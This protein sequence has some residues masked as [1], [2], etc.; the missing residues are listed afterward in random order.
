M[1]VCILSIKC[2]NYIQLY[3]VQSKSRF[4]QRSHKGFKAET[5]DPDGLCSNPS[6]TPYQLCVLGQLT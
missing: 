6:S 1:H 5:L 2:S 4:H 3:V